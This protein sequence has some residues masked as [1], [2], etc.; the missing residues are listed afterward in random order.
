MSPS[1]VI[2]GRPFRSVFSS[3]YEYISRM[4]EAFEHV[5]RR[6]TGALA[7]LRLVHERPGVTR[8]EVGRSLGMSTGSTTEITARLRAE[9]LLSEKM[10]E[11]ARQRGRPSGRLVA[12]EEGPVVLAVLLAPRPCRVGAGQRG[13]RVGGPG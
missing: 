1:R 6:G 4:A 5:D 8:A 7:V 9:K 10:P 2:T 12:H 11:G 13:R 3:P